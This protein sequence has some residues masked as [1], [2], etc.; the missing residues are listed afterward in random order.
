MCLPAFPP[1]RLQVS[2]N[3]QALYKQTLTD[4]QS[5]PNL[6]NNLGSSAKDVANTICK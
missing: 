3:V 5:V 1:A 6:L 2:A 4:A